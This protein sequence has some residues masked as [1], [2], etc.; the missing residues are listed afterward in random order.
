MYKETDNVTAYSREKAINGDLLPCN[1]SKKRKETKHSAITTFWHIEARQS[2]TALE[3]PQY[4]L[5]I[6]TVPLSRAL[7]SNPHQLT[8]SFIIRV[9]DKDGLSGKEW[10]RVGKRRESSFVFLLR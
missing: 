8:L 1:F 4:S 5:F 2:L 7:T 10:K 6:F 3:D 9:M